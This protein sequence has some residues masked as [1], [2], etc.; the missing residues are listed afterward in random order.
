M[1][2]LIDEMYSPEVAE[3][4]RDLRHDAISAHDRDDLQAAPDQDIFRLMQQ[5]GRVI[6]TN[7]HRDYAPLANAA[8]QAR[9]DF[10]GLVYTSD[11]SLPRN[12]KTIPRMV[13]RLSDLLNRHGSEEQL[14]T[15]I[16][17]LSP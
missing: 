5:E 9:D 16:E 14:P 12:K 6:V 15:G 13:E 11:K 8:L 2:L 10:F 3:R 4:L 1:R 7:N 17:W